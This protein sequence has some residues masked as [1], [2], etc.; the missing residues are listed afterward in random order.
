VEG[1][2]GDLA[3]NSCQFT[4]ADLFY[5]EEGIKVKSIKGLNNTCA[6]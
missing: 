3:F 6:A 2:L 1:K 5:K 4:Y